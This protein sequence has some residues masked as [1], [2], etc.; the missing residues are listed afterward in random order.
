[1]CPIL[2][3][4]PC[5]PKYNLIEGLWEWMKSEIVNNALY[6]STAAIIKGPKVVIN[7]LCVKL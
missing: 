4:P 5:S 2:F 6:T 3:M 1:M 7:R